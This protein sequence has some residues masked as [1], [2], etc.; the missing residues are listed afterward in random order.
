MHEPLSWDDLRFVL[1]LHRRRTFTAAAGELGVNHST[2]HR[3]L[4]RIEARLGVRLFDRASDGCIAT[5][6][7]EEAAAVAERLESDVGGL[8]RRI[9]GRDTRPTGIVRLTTTDTLLSGG[10]APAL[11]AC[12]VGHPGIELEVV[13]DN[14]F[15][16]LNKRDADIAVRP[17]RAVPESLV[18]RRVARIATAVYAAPALAPSIDPERPPSPGALAGLPWIAGDESLAH[19]PSMRWLAE[20]FPDARPVARLNRLPGILALAEAG[21][22]LATLPCFMGDAAPGL[23]RVG[24]PLAELD[25]PLWL[26]THRDL[27]RVARIRA[28]LDTL[29]PA[30]AALAPRFAGEAAG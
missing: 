24:A 17:S 16:A 2:A 27:T 1:A 28:V 20:S 9:A 23:V 7:G 26:L 14:R 19:L 13:V 12:R 21:V 15:L 18:G 5:P 8:E 29:A 11:A 10:L 6:A 22:G 30:L 25:T 4:A 3:R